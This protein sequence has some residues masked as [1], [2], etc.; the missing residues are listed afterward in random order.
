MKQWWGQEG[1]ERKNAGRQEGRQEGEKR[2]FPFTRSLPTG[3]PQPG[4][5]QAEARIQFHCISDVGGRGPS[6][7]AITLLPT[8]F[9]TDLSLKPSSQDTG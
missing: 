6:D 7:G 1:R 8:K 5:D 3:L 2:Y 4:M 9:S